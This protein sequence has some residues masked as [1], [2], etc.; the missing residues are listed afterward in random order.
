MAK[1]SGQNPETE[2]YICYCY[3]EVSNLVPSPLSLYLLQFSLGIILCSFREFPISN[4]KVILTYYRNSTNAKDN[5]PPGM[6][7]EN[8]V[9]T[10]LLLNF[11]LQSHTAIQGSKQFS[12]QDAWRLTFWD[13]LSFKSL[14]CFARRQ[15]QL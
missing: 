8:G 14:H 7:V 5:C 4:N 3:K 13:S 9:T 6:V 1:T 10:P 2:D 15:F 11:Y 12:L